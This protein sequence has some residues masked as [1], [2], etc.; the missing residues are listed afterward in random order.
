MSHARVRLPYLQI[1]PGLVPVLPRPRLMC[2]ISRFEPSKSYPP[3]EPM[4]TRRESTCSGGLSI[5]LTA[6]LDVCRTSH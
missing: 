2:R 1:L 3:V 5:A 4:T 6:S